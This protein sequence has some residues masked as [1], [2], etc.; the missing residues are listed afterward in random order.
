MRQPLGICAVA[1]GDQNMGAFGDEA[2]DG[3]ASDSAAAAGN[4]CVFSIRIYP[5]LHRER[6]IW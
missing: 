3:G 5:L 4:D 6:T 1:V 2:A